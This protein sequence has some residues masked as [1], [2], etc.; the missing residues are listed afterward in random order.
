MGSH[1]QSR[2]GEGFKPAQLVPGLLSLSWRIPSI[3]K[4]MRGI[5]GF[6]NDSPLSMGTILE[7]NAEKYATNTALL[8]ED[9]RITHEAFNSRINQYAHYLSSRG[10]NK[11]DIALVLVDNRPEL[12][13]VIGALSKLGAVASLINPNQRGKVLLHSINLTRGRTFIVGEELLEA[14]EE[15]KGELELTPEDRLYYQPES[16]QTGAPD[17]YDN[18]EKAIEEQPTSNP[19]STGETKLGDPFAYV[20]TSGTTGLPKASVQT[21]RRWFSAMYWF[22]KIVMNLKP[23]DVHYCPLPFCH[24]NGLNVAWGSCAGCGT[25]LAIRRRFSASQFLSDSRKFKANSFIYVGEVCRYLMNQP[26]RPD[27]SD[28]PIQAMVGNGLRPDI[29]KAFKK[30]FGISRVYELYGAAEAPLIFSNLLNVDCT[31]GMCLTPFAIVEYD[32]DADEP[33]RGEDGFMRKVP[34]GGAGLL[35]AEISESMPFVGYT[36]K[37]ETERKIFRDVFEKGD[38]WFNSG[39]LVFN[40]GFKHI[41][42]VDR[43]GDTFRWKGENV[44]T[45]EVENVV[46]TLHQVDQSTAYGVMIPG[47][48]GRAGMVAIIPATGVE[49]FDLKA[50]A[51]TV[52]NALPSY[53]VPKFVRFK[54]A[55]ETTGTHKI[56]KKVLRDEGFDPNVVDDP[57]YVLLPEGAAYQPLTKELYQEILEGKHRF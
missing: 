15:I 6:R 13:M 28:N 30:R 8:Y 51:E 1:V 22:G 16:G 56:K 20:F 36:E 4:T 41:Q 37:E 24:T 38:I 49:A 48:D 45:S 42:F 47:T 3:V 10:V 53:A 34:A 17:G 40:Q 26:A 19:P 52:R 21:H 9:I 14:F 25:A 50:L 57:L 29:W 55:F 35:L 32:T 33:V 31:V 7:R 11:G 43:L 27:D 2:A 12:L 39:D 18:L 5:L 44:S 23:T 54:E 46:N